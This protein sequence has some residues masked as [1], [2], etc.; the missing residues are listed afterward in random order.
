MNSQFITESHSM[1]KHK[2]N[3]MPLPYP[4][5]GQSAQRYFVRH[6]INKSAWAAAMGIERTTM[7]HL[8]SGSLKG[9]RGAAHDAAIKLG[10]KEQPNE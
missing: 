4:Q 6:G 9:R 1:E 8:L 2:T 10:L 7:E 3:F 5:S